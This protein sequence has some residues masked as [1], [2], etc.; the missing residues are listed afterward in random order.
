EAYRTR[1]ECLAPNIFLLT[2]RWLPRWLWW[3]VPSRRPMD[4]MAVGW[5][6]PQEDEFAL[7]ILGLPSPYQRIAFP[8]RPA[9]DDAAL[10]LHGLSPRARRRWMATFLQWMSE[11][12]F[13]KGGRR[14]ILKSP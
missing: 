12:T 3:M 10:D 6:R 2:G 5:D 7:C 11:L 1:Y 14:L 4:N 8:N 9:D 13:A